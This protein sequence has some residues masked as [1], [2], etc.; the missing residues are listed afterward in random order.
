MA[1]LG[2]LDGVAEQVRE[3]L[4]HPDRIADDGGGNRRI[5]IAEELEPLLIG[6]ERQRLQQV[7]HQRAD[8][9]GNRLE[10]ELARL[11]LREVEDVVE[12][13]EQR[14]RRR[15]DRRQAI[16][17]LGRQLA[18]QR[19]LGHAEDA[20]HRRPD[21]VAHVGE[22]LALG[23]AG[24]HRLVARADEIGVGG[25]QLGGARLDGLL[26]LILVMQQLQVPLLNLAEHL[27]ES[28]DQLADLVVAAVRLGAKVVAPLARD[29]ARD[30]GEPHQRH[31]DDALQPRRQRPGDADAPSSTRARMRTNA[32][33]R[34]RSSSRSEETKTVPMTSRSSWIGRVTCRVPPVN[35]CHG[36]C[37]RTVVVSL[38]GGDGAAPG[39]W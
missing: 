34:V 27:V 30:A 32:M 7:L 5:E 31:G 22:E 23:A 8:R 17:L 10:L 14:L 9:E 4:P 26:E 36:A 25:A 33:A 28:A 21:F 37:V 12:D 11:D 39:R 2:E 19:Q 13:R 6:F 38:S 1:A 20:V 24:F 18:V 3:H 15:L 29:G 16:A 35:A